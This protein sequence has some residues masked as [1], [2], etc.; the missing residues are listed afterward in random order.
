M[1][2]WCECE[3]MVSGKTAD[4]KEFVDAAKL[5]DCVLDFNRFVPYPKQ[6]ADADEA[7]DKWDAMWRD[8]IN[9]MGDGAVAAFTGKHPRPESGFSD[10][11]R[12]WCVNNWGTKWNACKTTIESS[13][14]DKIFYHFNTAWAPPIP[15]IRKMG[16]ILP[17]LKFSL[18]Y[19]ECGAGYQGEFSMDKGVVVNDHTAEYDGP[20]GG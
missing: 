1:P 8:K 18:E 5:G 17:N 15:V 9:D 2:N 20:R 16:E 3:L 7:V 6:Y 4:L 19:W 12:A 14:T 11:G 10:G 13:S